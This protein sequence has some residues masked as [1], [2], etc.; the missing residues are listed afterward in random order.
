MNRF[1]DTANFLKVVQ[2]CRSQG[3]SVIDFF[4]QAIQAMVKADMLAPSLIPQ[5]FT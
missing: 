3:L 5:I 4:E 1:K 2:T